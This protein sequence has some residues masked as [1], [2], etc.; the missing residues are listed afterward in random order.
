MFFIG[1]QH[2]STYPA[3]DR[4]AFLIE[5]ACVPRA[6]PTFCAETAQLLAMMEAAREKSEAAGTSGRRDNHINEE[7]Q[8]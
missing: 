6:Y 4:A 8:L 2:E 7:M 5:H 3:L 1:I